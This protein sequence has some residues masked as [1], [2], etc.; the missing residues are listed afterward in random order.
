MVD[1]QVANYLVLEWLLNVYT[2][3]APP[4]RPPHPSVWLTLPALL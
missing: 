3:P 4:L 1:G 2:I